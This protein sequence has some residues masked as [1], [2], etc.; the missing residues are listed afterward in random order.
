MLT[1]FQIAHALYGSLDFAQRRL[2]KLNGDDLLGRFR[3]F[4]AEG[5]T[6]PYH[7]TYLGN[8]ASRS[9]LPNAATTSRARIR[10]AGDG[11]T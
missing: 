5:G 11:G 7:Y 10:L 1:S 3:P 2:R 4:R 9:S 8:S 6:Y